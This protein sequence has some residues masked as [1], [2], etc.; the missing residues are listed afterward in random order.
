MGRI[1][2]ARADEPLSGK[3]LMS[4]ELADCAWARCGETIAQNGTRDNDNLF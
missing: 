1:S 3:E 4:N 2:K